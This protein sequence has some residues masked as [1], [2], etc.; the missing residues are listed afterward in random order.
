L[1]LDDHDGCLADLDQAAELG[2]SV[3][4]VN[5]LRGLA[6]DQADRWTEAIYAFDEVLDRD[7][8]RVVA[9]LGR[10]CA[11][12]S[13]GDKTGAVTDLTYVLELERE[14]ADCLALRGDYYVELGDYEAARHDYD[15]AMNIAGQSYSMLVRYATA[16][17]RLRNAGSAENTG[18]ARIRRQPETDTGNSG[19]TSD[20]S[21]G[22]FDDW[23]RRQLSVPP[24]YQKKVTSSSLGPLMANL[25]R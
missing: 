22:S 19:P 3:L 24:G 7:P 18:A 9:R 20:T 21:T 2:A 16:L 25:R 6:L 12:A 10:A 17:S 23:L 1:L 5:T 13:L 4:W 14:N 11:R 15:E 8:D